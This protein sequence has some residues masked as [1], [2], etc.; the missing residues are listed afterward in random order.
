MCRRDITLLLYHVIYT[1]TM[2]TLI[3]N[4]LDIRW[5]IDSTGWDVCR[6]YSVWAGYE[7]YIYSNFPNTNDIK[8]YILCNNIPTLNS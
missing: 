3:H 7:L 8:R 6:V 2:T 5:D 4:K 1:I